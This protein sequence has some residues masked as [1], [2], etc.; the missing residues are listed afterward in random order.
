[1][2]NLEKIHPPPPRVG[3]ITHEFCYY[4]SW[5][6]QV[7]RQKNWNFKSSSGKSNLKVEISKSTN[8]ITISNCS[9]V[10][11]VNMEI[12][13]LWTLHAYLG[14]FQI[15]MVEFFCENR[16]RF[17]TAPYFSKNALAMNIW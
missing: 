14:F 4:K 1:M 5:S 13:D 2:H 16:Q 6:F 8:P 17:K 10:V 7:K 12:T 11:L 15:T 9:A 3:L